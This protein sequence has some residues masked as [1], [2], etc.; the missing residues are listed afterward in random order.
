MYTEISKAPTSYPLI[1]EKFNCEKLYEKLDITKPIHEQE[2]MFTAYLDNNKEVNVEPGHGVLCIFQGMD[3][4]N[5]ILGS[6]RINPAAD[7]PIELQASIGG[8]VTKGM[9]IKDSLQK[10][11]DYKTHE[12]FPSLNEFSFSSSYFCHRKY[13]WD[14]CYLTLIATSTKKY[15]LDELKEIAISINT[16]SKTKAESKDH[17]FY[18]VYE[19]KEI[20][21]AAQK[22]K[23]LPE[24]SG[25]PETLL[26]NYLNEETKNYVIFDDIATS[27]L[28]SSLKDIL[29]PAE[30]KGRLIY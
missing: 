22:T 6:P 23:G 25:K 8:R 24:G 18:E 11:L 27:G 2:G 29:E 14:M 28:A 20:I 9:S 16:A 5:Y 21:S 7:K 26:K 3:G 12:K 4:K 17:F 15:S 30:N 1:K 13:E 19:L 10:T